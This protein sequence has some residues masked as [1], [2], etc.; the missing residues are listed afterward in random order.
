MDS[1]YWSKQSKRSARKIG[2]HKPRCLPQEF[3]CSS[4]SNLTFNM[5]AQPPG[6]KRKSDAPDLPQDDQDLLEFQ[7]Q[8]KKKTTKRTNSKAPANV[9]EHLVGKT[10]EEI[11][12]MRL[13]Q[14]LEEQEQRARDLKRTNPKEFVAILPRYGVYLSKKDSGSANMQIIAGYLNLPNTAAVWETFIHN[15]E[16]RDVLDKLYQEDKVSEDLSCSIEGHRAVLASRSCRS[17]RI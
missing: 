7:I 5:A 8:K 3:P 2:I 1:K 6:K 17:G 11:Y 15:Q 10:D 13:P 9:G 4:H 12:Q 16:V 14:L